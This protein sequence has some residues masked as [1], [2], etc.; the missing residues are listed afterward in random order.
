M[1]DRKSKWKYYF[2][3]G[4]IKKRLPWN[5]QLCLHRLFT[6]MFSNLEGF[7]WSASGI[8]IG[9]T[10]GVRTMVVHP[11]KGRMFTDLRSVLSSPDIWQR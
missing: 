9:W 4:S 10:S 1:H 5:T 3:N 11:G 7:Q 6:F 2:F 8:D